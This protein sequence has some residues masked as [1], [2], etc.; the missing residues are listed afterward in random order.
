MAKSDN[1][2]LNNL[3]SQFQVWFYIQPT[4]QTMSMLSEVCATLEKCE[5]RGGKTLSLLHQQM[6]G[7]VGNEASRAVAEFLIKTASKPYFKILGE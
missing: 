5:S 2:T 4:L 1:F 7:Q 3:L 6:I